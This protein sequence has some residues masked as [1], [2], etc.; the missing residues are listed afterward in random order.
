MNCSMFGI[1]VIWEEISVVEKRLLFCRFA[2]S[3]L[4]VPLKYDML[5][6]DVFWVTV[7][8]DLTYICGGAT[9]DIFF[10]SLKINISF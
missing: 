9:F 5:A 1:S 6:C 3:I 10:N 4:K 8:R 2:M 7:E